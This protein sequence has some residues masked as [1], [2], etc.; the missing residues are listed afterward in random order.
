M[1]PLR[2]AATALAVLTLITAPVLTACSQD[3][4]GSDTSSSAASGSTSASATSDTE[5]KDDEDKETSAGS[6]PSSQDDA[7]AKPA[8][9]DSQEVTGASTGLTFTV[10]KDW[11]EVKTLSTAEKEAIAQSLNMSRADFEHTLGT[12]DLF[13]RA[14]D[15]NALQFHNNV[16]MLSQTQSLDSPPSESD[17]KSQLTA[18]GGRLQEYSTKQTPHGEAAAAVYL[19]EQ[20]GSV[21]AGSIIM[22]PTSPST[23]GRTTYATINVSASNS[24]DA[25]EITNTIL[26]TIH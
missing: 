26:D 15:A 6:T 25:K 22:V 20:G 19:T 18:Q 16:G 11:V 24:Q 9:G 12:Y 21:F 3:T 7:S 10:P 17:L 14:K 13:Y 1:K 5:E 8:P 2:T 23:G 4:R